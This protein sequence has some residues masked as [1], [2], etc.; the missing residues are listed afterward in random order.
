MFRT[1]CPLFLGFRTTSAVATLFGRFSY[2]RL[3][4]AAAARR[5]EL[6]TPDVLLRVIKIYF[7]HVFTS[8]LRLL[9]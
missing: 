8:F 2:H 4:M 9:R 3:N 5:K 6:E 7:G 1:V